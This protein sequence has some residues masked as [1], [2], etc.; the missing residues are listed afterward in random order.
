MLLPTLHGFRNL[1]ATDQRDKVY[2]IIGI[3]QSPDDEPPV[4]VDY[5]KPVAQVYC[6]VVEG[7]MKDNGDLQVLSYVEHPTEYEY[8]G[9]VPSWIPLWHVS[10]KVTRFL[11]P[12]NNIACAGRPMQVHP[13]ISFN[14]ECASLT[15]TGI[16]LDRV[17]YVSH[18]IEAQRPLFSKDEK[19]KKLITTLAK[20]VKDPQDNTNA[21]EASDSTEYEPSAE[22]IATA[23]TGGFTSMKSFTQ[24]ST[25][26]DELRRDETIR[27]QYMEGF[28]R[29]VRG[30]QTEALPSQRFS[31]EDMA[32]LMCHR[33]RIFR[34]SR[35]YIGLGP[36][37]MH[38]G[39][40]VAVLDGGKVPFVL[41]PLVDGGHEYALMG[42]CFVYDIMD[43]EVLQ[44]VGHD[45]VQDK[46]FVLR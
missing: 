27:T 11:W 38:V 28:W 9:D 23:F 39:D 43:G 8:H 1:Q 37:C 3:V 6:D 42:E 5:N 17:S 31:F 33:R 36:R 2:G 24:E 25:Y 34:T 26:I 18:S 7:A 4:E 21:I 44:M 20:L 22:A 46:T 32:R 40:I 41:R 10:T 16:Y 13:N 35:G 30:E 29:C 45:G 19:L 14:G 12:R 15:L